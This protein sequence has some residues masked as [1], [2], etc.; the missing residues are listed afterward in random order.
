MSP[1]DTPTATN[2]VQRGHSFGLSGLVFKLLLPLPPAAKMTRLSSIILLIFLS[3]C[4]D[5]PRYAQ[6]LN[7]TEV[8]LINRHDQPLT[9]VTAFVTGRSYFVGIIPPGDSAS[10]FAQPTS[11]SH[12]TLTHFQRPELLVVGAYFE[13]G[14]GGMIRAELL[15]DS[16][17]SVYSRFGK[18]P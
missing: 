12:V 13:P 18:Y 3:G 8:R 16:V 10:F 5:A 2:A 11:E 6:G 9:D 15:P 14:Y 4:I 7:P 17:V 1:N